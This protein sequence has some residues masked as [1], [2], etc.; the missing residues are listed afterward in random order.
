VR[1]SRLVFLPL[2]ADC[3]LLVPF[4]DELRQRA[5]DEV[6][7]YETAWRASNVQ[8]YNIDFQRD[9][10]GLVCDVSSTRP[11]RVHVRNAGIVKVSDGRGGEV[12]PKDGVSWPSVDSM[13]VWIRQ[14]LS[15][16]EYSI[17]IVF[18]TVQHI[19]IYVRTDDQR[20]A[21]IAN[22]FWNLDTLMTDTS[23]AVARSNYWMGAPFSKSKSVTWRSR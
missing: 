21:S 18:D 10:Y 16:K 17:E 11:V 3:T 14:V 5:L 23:A 7:R 6:T 9:C 1:L 12:A 13:Y 8:D 20:S 2:L 22:Y 19:P 4:R 15:A